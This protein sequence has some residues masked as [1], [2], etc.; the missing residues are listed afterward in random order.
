MLRSTLLRGSSAGAL[1]LVLVS[2]ALAQEALPAIDVGA[3]SGPAGPAGP[4]PAMGRENP[5]KETGYRRTTSVS[6]T[7]TETPLID[8]PVAVQIVP[9]EVI[10]DQQDLNIMEAVKNVSGV[11]AQPG[12][13][14]DQYRIRGFDSGYGATYRNGLK[15]EGILG[16]EEIA[17]TDRVE[18]VKGPASVLY[19]RIEPGGFVNVVTKKPQEDFKAVLEQQGGSFGLARST[20]DVTGSANESKTV[21]YRLMGAFDHADSFTDF[22]HHNNGA[23]AA[24]FTFRPTSN[25]E[26]NAQ[27]EHYEKRQTTPDGSGLIPVNTLFDD[28]GKPII[29]RGANDRPLNLPRHFSVSDPILWSD[30][31]YTVHRTLY[32]YDWTYKIADSWKITNRFHYLDSNENQTGLT[33]RSFDNVDTIARRFVFNPLQRNILNTNLDVNGEI[34]TGPLTHK[35]LAGV[36]WYS[37]VDNWGPGDTIGRAPD[38]T[39]L[40]IFAPQYGSA[41]PLLYLRKFGALSNYLWRTRERDFGVYGQDQISLLDDRLHILLGGRWDKAEVSQSKTYGNI[42]ADCYPFC[43]GYPMSRFP[44]KPE[45]SP[46]AGI[47]FKLSDNVSAYGSYVRS[48]GQSN[49]ANI[50]NGTVPPPEEGI[51]WEA[52]LKSQWLNGRLTGSIT[53]FDLRRKNILEQDPLNPD[54]QIAI[55]EVQSRGIELDLAGQVTENLSLIGSYTYDVAKITSDNN[56]G[57][58]GHVFNGVAPHVGNLWAKWDTA[59]GLPE[60]WEFGGGV[61]AMS[62]R[63]GNDANTWILPSYVR[64][65]AMAAYRTVLFGQKVAFRL[66]L[67][68][69]TDARYFAY[70]DAVSG[71]GTN[72]YYGQPR[73][74]IGSVSF[75]F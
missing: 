28:N 43:T 19:G 13:Y 12:T 64:F 53:L 20:V 40:N 18:V 39:E 22:D 60:G 73:A 2:A 1:T 24:F 9:H 70:S 56:N 38:G 26:F 46:R 48:F 74:V 17:F 32:Y 44:D 54:Y 15:M 4:G 69:L 21:L 63:W 66:N 33:T 35:V 57:N 49:G 37:Y 23:V 11:Q 52:G 27:I 50:A 31:P 7:K 30:F 16:S 34:A 55:G 61:Y 3:A 25:F 65:D 8:T 10:Q 72:A 51:Q 6:A 47:L 75:Q 41:G 14:Y 29:F 59:P 71:S 62:W 67:K 5:S 58:K 42:F 68:N 36:D 45:L